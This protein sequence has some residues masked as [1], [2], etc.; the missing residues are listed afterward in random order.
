MNVDSGKLRILNGL[1]R[2]RKEHQEIVYKPKFIDIDNIVIYG[3]TGNISLSSIKW[4]MKHDI[5]ISVIDW[6]GRL[7]TNMNPPQSKHSFV[8]MAQY[9]AYENGLRID[10]ARNFRSRKD[11]QDTSL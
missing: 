4:L 7:L 9:K 11:L 3:H 2:N 8:K 5:P 10:L 1:D 6:N